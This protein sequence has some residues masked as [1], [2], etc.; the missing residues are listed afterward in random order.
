MKKYFLLFILLGLFSSCQEEVKGETKEVEEVVEHKHKSFFKFTYNVD[1]K[2]IL[3]EMGNT[4]SSWKTLVNIKVYEYNKYGEKIY[5]HNFENVKYQDEFFEDVK[6]E[7]IKVKV[8]VDTKI[9]FF[10]TEM[11]HTLSWIQEQF[12]IEEEKTIY[13]TLDRKTIVGA[14][15]PI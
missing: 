5:C 7:T 1:M 15:E 4:G 14:N 8:F 10:T 3:N 9:S 12:F 6:E 2:E 13:I 11:E